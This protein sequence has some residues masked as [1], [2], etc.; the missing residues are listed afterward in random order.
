MSQVFD[1]TEW[2]DLSLWGFLFATYGT[3]LLIT[4]MM[5]VGSKCGAPQ[6]P[7]RIPAFSPPSYVIAL[8]FFFLLFIIAFAGFRGDKFAAS[9]N[10]RRILN[11]LFA[12]QLLFLVLWAWVLTVLKDFTTG[13]YL[14]IVVAILAIVWVL[15][16][17]TIDRLS[18]Y[19]LILYVLWVVFLSFWNYQVMVDNPR[20]C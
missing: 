8:M 9:I 17:F 4:I 20:A 15:A 1:L 7:V 6:I 12:V 5:Q 18:A 19:L 13:F 11:G 2:N 14:S 16:L 3:A 10:Q